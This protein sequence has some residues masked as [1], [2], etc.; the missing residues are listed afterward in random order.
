L[1]RADDVRRRRRTTYDEWFRVVSGVL[2]R[3]RARV[4]TFA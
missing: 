2:Y 1:T 3:V 4:T